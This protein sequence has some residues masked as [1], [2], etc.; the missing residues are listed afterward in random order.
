[1]YLYRYLTICEFLGESTVIVSQ[2]PEKP[3][4]I[5]ALGGIDSIGASAVLVCTDGVSLLLDCGVNA[6]RPDD[7]FPHGL[8]KIKVDALLLSHAH[9]DHVGALPIFVKAH[10]DVPVYATSAT[11]KLANVM[12]KD[13]SLHV[14]RNNPD[15]YTQQEGE[16]AAQSIREVEFE[17]GFPIGR[18]VARFRRAGHIL[19]AAT[20][21]IQGSYTLVY[22]G[23]FSINPTRLTP[24]AILPGNTEP[25][26]L[27]FSETTYGARDADSRQDKEFVEAVGHTLSMQG[28]VLIPSFALG[29]AQEVIVLLSEAMA[30]GALPKVPVYVDGL[31]KQVNEVY[32]GLKEYVGDPSVQSIL[33]DYSVV[34]PVVSWEMRLEL[35]FG[36]ESCVIISSSGML[37]GG[38]SLTY[39]KD[40]TSREDSAIFFVGYLDEDS[41]G[42]ALRDLASGSIVIDNE[43]FAPKCKVSGFN[44]S[45]HANREQVVG[46]CSKYR[47]NV[48]VP[49]HG[50]QKAR[51]FIGS[52]V[53]ELIGSLSLYPYNGQI[54]DVFPKARRYE[55]VRTEDDQAS[56]DFLSTVNNQRVLT[57]QELGEK[58]TEFLK[59]RGMLNEYKVAEEF[60]WD[61]FKN[62]ANITSVD[63]W[64]T[65]SQRAVFLR[66]GEIMLRDNFEGR[67]GVFLAKFRKNI[68][69]FLANLTLYGVNRIWV[70]LIQG[71]PVETLEDAEAMLVQVWK[72]F[73]FRPRPTIVDVYY[74]CRIRAGWPLGNEFEGKFR[75]IFAKVE[76]SLDLL[77]AL[78]G[79]DLLLIGDAIVGAVN[80]QVILVLAMPSVEPVGSKP[81]TDPI[82][83]ISGSR[84][85]GIAGWSIDPVRVRPV[86]LQPRVDSAGDAVFKLT[87]ELREILATAV[88]PFRNVAGGAVVLLS[89]LSAVLEQQ[90]FICEFRQ[91]FLT[92]IHSDSSKKILVVFDH[93]GER[94]ADYR[95]E[96]GCLMGIPQF[97]TAILKMSK[98]W[99][100]KRKQS[101]KR[102]AQGL[103][104]DV[105]TSYGWHA[106]LPP[107]QR[108]K[109]LENSLD[110]YDYGY[111]VRVLNFLK[112]YTFQDKPDLARR[113]GE[114]LEWLQREFGFDHSEKILAFERDVLSYCGL[115]FKRDI[116]F[117]RIIALVT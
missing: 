35:L 112:V 68:A 106:R 97:E 21:I 25:C 82:V 13:A 115:I 92:A 83:E 27:L 113:V 56:V 74:R 19:G 111:L 16:E 62:S 103:A 85:L 41:P 79:I 5:H 49:I 114:D 46:L 70:G 36:N 32:L 23:D 45:A 54:L 116:N 71:V 94:F 14:P 60:A 67:D 69:S 66:A 7:P 40:F 30:R 38:W 47:P 42:R 1:M 20:I 50:D 63:P 72:D 44:L 2:S 101:F 52:E 117:A 81:V 100:R 87:D 73:D 102:D 6:G 58:M 33:G 11:K 90:G 4:R 64:L 39:A 96:P 10:R 12:L 55:L 88:E 84:L 108:R 104:V 57:P 53:N 65:I 28:R 105:I 48:L 80:G 95:S 22:T 31:V 51:H 75:R 3:I 107:D 8:K 89:D 18:L 98:I 15:H 109:A 91:K 34:K 77:K 61:V 29:R 26:D 43:E 99:R 37:T 76:A 110:A 24:G 86:F 9:I 59:T 17:K 78:Q 93:N